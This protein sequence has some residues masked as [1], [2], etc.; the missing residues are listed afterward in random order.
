LK[1][2]FN[3]NNNNNK[4]KSIFY[5]LNIKTLSV[6]TNLRMS[7]SPNNVTGNADK[8]RKVEDVIANATNDEVD[9][10][11]SVQ[12]SYR[13]NEVREI[14]KVL[15]S[16]E[17]GS[18]ESSKLRLAMQF[19]DAVFKAA[20]SLADYHKRLTKRLKKVQ[21]S[22]KPPEQ[23]DK[24]VIANKEREMQEMRQLYGNALKYIMKHSA[25]AFIEMKEKHGEEKAIQLKQHTDGVV[26]WAADLGLLD[27]NP[28]PNLTISNDQIKKLKDH[29]ERRLDN[30]RCHVAKLAEPDS[31]IAENLEKVE[32]EF[33]GKTSAATL[34]A[35]YSKKRFEMWLKKN[36]NPIEILMESMEQASRNVPL[37]TRNQRN[38]ERAA[39]IYLD[40]MRASGTAM[41][42]YIA[43]KEKDKIPRNT[44]VKA[45]NIAREGIEFVQNVMHEH[46]KQQ[47]PIEISLQDA[48]MKPLVLQ[49]P[50][51]STD[52][53]LDATITTPPQ[54]TK[55]LKTSHGR[56]VIRSRV[57]LTT[58]RKPPTNLLLALQ[59]KRAKL[60][61]P[62]PNGTGSYLIL[63][64][65]KAFIMNVYFV[66]LLVTI[67]AYQNLDCVDDDDGIW[68]KNQY[69]KS[70]MSSFDLKCTQYLPLNYGLLD[71]TRQ[72]LN[73]Y[74]VKGTYETIG[75]VIEERL[76][77]CSAHATNVLRKCFAK[78][79]KSDAKQD[80]EIEIY[81][82]SALLEFLH[83]ARTTYI[84]NWEDDDTI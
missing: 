42:A 74:G 62:P 30:I 40:K 41:F 78:H 49:S 51:T 46:R 55:R 18:K 14:A 72:Q 4:G 5:P 11:L 52:D 61:R 6:S 47:K 35:E 24:Q 20:T 57:L 48:W 82:A 17:P 76:R 23:N 66:P 25:K 53:T 54:Q 7:L 9:W 68:N 16:L 22:Y 36:M 33:K 12:Q 67:R 80:F 75:Y 43:T 15:S 84:P 10:R 29:L 27:S 37:P 60:I 34:L 63:E 32:Q 26:I 70:S 39:L 79:V 8:K 65:E 13:N 19:E 31:F 83:L 45:H 81:E 73:V 1:F 77:D 21:K 59:R 58:N 38:D 28:K 50:I 69:L 3:N 56:P 71:R 64:F 2:H 44:L